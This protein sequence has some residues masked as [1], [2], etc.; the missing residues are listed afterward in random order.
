MIK[1]IF[2]IIIRI[3]VELE[4]TELLRL[5]LEKRSLYFKNFGLPQSTSMGKFL[6]KSTFVN[7]YDQEVDKDF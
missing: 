1:S 5:E 6:V 3:D 4:K 2:E 7:C